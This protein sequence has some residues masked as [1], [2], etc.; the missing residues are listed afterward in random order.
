MFSSSRTLPGLWYAISPGSAL[1]QISRTSFLDASGPQVSDSWRAR[2]GKSRQNVAKRATRAQPRLVELL[3]RLAS[4]GKAWRCIA[5]RTLRPVAGTTVAGTSPHGPNRWMRLA[6]GPLI[7]R[8]GALHNEHR[9]F[10]PMPRVAEVRTKSDHDGTNRPGHRAPG[11]A[12]I[13]SSRLEMGTIVSIA[14]P[15]EHRTDAAT[16][17]SVLLLDPSRPSD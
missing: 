16:G 15:I 1:R 10:R 12:G 8:V 5:P 2:R 13:G 6:R 17:G 3:T 14:S 7:P 4:G 11:C 9:I